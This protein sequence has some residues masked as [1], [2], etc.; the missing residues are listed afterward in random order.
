MSHW[1][2]V[3]HC[4]CN[5]KMNPSNSFIFKFNQILMTYSLEPFICC[6]VASTGMPHSFPHAPCL[7]LTIF[8]KTN[9]AALSI[10]N[11]NHPYHL[12]R[13]TLRLAHKLP[14]LFRIKPF[15]LPSSA[16]LQCLFARLNFDTPPQCNNSPTYQRQQL[17]NDR[18][19]FVP[20]IRQ[21]YNASDLLANRTY[22]CRSLSIP[23]PFAL[24]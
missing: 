6:R 20:Q 2:Q 14:R 18:P 10:V 9:L 23:V 4:G 16:K 13:P 11:L 3:Q 22:H 7:C 19:C 8:P 17:H 1:Q 5:D 15:R 21:S 12:S 24:F